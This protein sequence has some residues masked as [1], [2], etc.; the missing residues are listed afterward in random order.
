MRVD[1]RFWKSVE[2]LGHGQFNNYHL[3]ATDKHTVLVTVNHAEPDPM[4]PNGCVT[5]PRHF[6]KELAKVLS[7]EAKETKQ[8][9]I[10]LKADCF[11]PGQV[12]TTDMLA[13]MVEQ[14]E[15]A[16]DCRF[17]VD[18][19]LLSKAVKC[20][21]AKDKGVPAIICDIYLRDGAA[22][23]RLQKRGDDTATAYVAGMLTQFFPETTPGS[24]ENADENE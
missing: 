11:E 14:F 4:Q 6:T 3:L 19:D 12:V 20:L 8:A 16:P 2:T 23:Y 10:E 9:S 7:K 1:A 17:A 24:V 18:W 21:T 15:G 22:F 13:R 5:E